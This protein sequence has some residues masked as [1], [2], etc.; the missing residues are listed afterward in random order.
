M[1]SVFLIYAYIFWYDFENRRAL[2]KIHTH[3]SML[4]ANYLVGLNKEGYCKY[5]ETATSRI[6]WQLLVFLKVIISAPDF[7]GRLLSLPTTYFSNGNLSK[8]V[9]GE[10]LRCE[11]NRYRC[12]ETVNFTWPD[13]ILTRLYMAS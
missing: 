11:K 2:L 12:N 3:C 4:I 6:I 8:L 7:V 1:Y 10:C 5:Y 9:E 13:Y